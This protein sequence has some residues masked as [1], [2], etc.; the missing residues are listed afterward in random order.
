MGKVFCELPT[1]SS[2][3]LLTTTSFCEWGTF[4]GNYSKFYLQILL[5]KDEGTSI[6]S[7]PWH[8]PD[9]Y[10]LPYS[11]FLCSSL[12][13]T[14]THITHKKPAEKLQWLWT[15]VLK[16]LGNPGLKLP[17]QRLCRWVMMQPSFP[18]AQTVSSGCS[19]APR[20]GGNRSE[21]V[22]ASK[23]FS[24]LAPASCVKESR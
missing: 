4:A 19:L 8:C 24:A 1:P 13:E 5:H 3:L 7:T 11:F 12:L 18:S 20:A 23:Q 9:S 16:K 21:A 22:K 17:R 6:F 2:T 10:L 15:R 14:R